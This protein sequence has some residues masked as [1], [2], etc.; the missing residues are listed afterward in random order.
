MRSG[1]GCSVTPAERVIVH[2]DG[3]RETGPGRWMARCPA[4]D[5]RSASISIKDAGDKVLLHCFAGC[6]VGDVLKAI[7]LSL[8]DLFDRP[9]EHQNA[10]TKYQRRTPWR[11][12]AQTIRQEI[13]VTVI[14][15]ERLC[16]GE[17]LSQ[18]DMG[19]LYLATRRLVEITE[20]TK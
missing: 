18:E 3:A 20:Q 16:G 5:D 1:T 7:G 9:P 17:I 11:D 15:G 12:L 6:D 10:L 13:F 8:S 4:H 2:L 14:S 19:R